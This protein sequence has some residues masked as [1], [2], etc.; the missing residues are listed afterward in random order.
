MKIFRNIP[1]LIAAGLIL[2]AGIVFYVTLVGVQQLVPVMTANED[3]SAY[4]IVREE[5]LKTI[6]LPK[7]AVDSQPWLLTQDE[8]QSNYL[9][10]KRALVTTAKIFK[11]ETIDANRVARSP[12]Q[13]FAVVLPDERVV[14]ASTTL[15]GSIVGAIQSGDVVDVSSSGNSAASVTA[16]KVLCITSK[17]DGCQGVLPSSIEPSTSGGSGTSSGAAATRDQANVSLILAVP[18]ADAPAIAGSVVTLNLN[19]F[20]SFNERGLFT[21]KRSDFKCQVP[22]DRLAAKGVAA[23]QAASEKSA[24]QAEDSAAGEQTGEGTTPTPE[25]GA[26]PEA[27]A[28]QETTPNNSVKP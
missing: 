19:T 12:Q 24:A 27:G 15:A 4:S 28:N 8:Y 25:G 13:S 20:C 21:N 2:V 23:L 16:A 5:Q 9:D 6:Q 11:G 3:I 18:A 22:G 10:K 14:S 7:K 26:A 1:V 17:P